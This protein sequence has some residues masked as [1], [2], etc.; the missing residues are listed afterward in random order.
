MVVPTNALHSPPM[1][2]TNS[3]VM[4]DDD[5]AEFPCFRTR[6]RARIQLSLEVSRR[7]RSNFRRK[8]W[9]APGEDEWQYYVWNKAVS[10]GTA[11]FRCID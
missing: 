7:L 4:L 1:G 6:R 11:P 3:G 9:R 5:E 10:V 8:H 2:K